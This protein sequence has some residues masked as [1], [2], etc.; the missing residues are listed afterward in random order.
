MDR[1]SDAGGVESIAN[2]PVRCGDIMPITPVRCA[3]LLLIVMAMGVAAPAV[4]DD[5]PTFSPERILEW[6][7]RSFQGHT[8]YTLVERDGVR[9]IEARCDN[10]ASGLFIE[11]TFDLEQTPILEWQWRVDTLPATNAD[12]TARPGDDFALRVYVI[13]DGGWRP[14]RSRAITYV[15]TRDVATG[16]NWANPWVEQVEMLAL[17]QGE[18]ET[19]EWLTERRNLVDDFQRLHDRDIERID[20]L[21]VMTDCDNTGTDA[22]AWYGRIRLLPESADS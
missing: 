18:A 19:G 13:V 11:G 14:W 15:W 12:E 20:G 17:R 3:H 10:S 4:A 5:T 22:R 8:E 9:A 2:D 21:A 6:E 7:E 1:L 16:R